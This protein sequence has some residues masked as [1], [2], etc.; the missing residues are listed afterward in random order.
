MIYYENILY[1]KFY[2]EK[3]LKIREELD[4][5]GEYLWNNGELS[6]DERQKAYAEL[7]AKN[8]KLMEA[9]IQRY[10]QL[11]APS[12]IIEDVKLVV[13]SIEKKEYLE[14][15]ESMIA[16]YFC[17]K[18]SG[19]EEDALR[20]DKQLKDTGSEDYKGAFNYIL[21]YLDI[22]LTIFVNEEDY[23]KKIMDL[24]EA[25]VSLW[26]VKPESSYLPVLKGKATDLA[27]LAVKSS[28]IEDRIAHTGTLTVKGDSE[29]LKATIKKFDEYR[30]KLSVST[31][32]LL[33]VAIANFANNNHIG[34]GNSRVLKST[35]VYISLKDY[36]RA[37]DIEVDLRP[38][39]TPEEKKKEANR[40]KKALSR[41]KKRAEEDLE[42][43]AIT[44]LSWEEKVKGKRENFLDVYP[45]DAKGIK[46]GYIFL[47]FSQHFA[48]YLLNLP[49]N[50]YPKALLKLDYRQSNAYMIG[51]K[52]VSHYFMDSNQLH[53]RANLLKVKTLLKETDLPTLEE[54]R[55]IRKNWV[56]RIKEPLENALDALGESYEADNKEGKSVERKGCGLL[57][58]WEYCHSKGVP[59]TD[60]E[61]SALL[62]SFEVWSE[63]L[64]KFTLKDTPDQSDRLDKKK[65]AIEEA[66]AKKAKKS[67]A[68]SKKKA[69]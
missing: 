58:S 17:F 43:L 22:P 68:D 13:N 69:E 66:K 29:P 12:D 50:Q 34:E 55:A 16:S 65:Q 21:S 28:L 18:D 31:D 49:M 36:A 30:A 20:I 51:K 61:A 62:D 39:N 54:V 67:S 3:M 23:T 53:N 32:Q 37:R 24:V 45:V 6:V 42:A 10:S 4:A 38:T 40:A 41:A 35:E 9:V 15:V 46:D 63:T 25:R 8:A 47:S 11:R 19:M 27:K 64:V 48:S 5:R 1:P 14:Y 60:K 52:L 7:R 57:E 33:N 44:P 26:Y 56:D 2:C 59:L